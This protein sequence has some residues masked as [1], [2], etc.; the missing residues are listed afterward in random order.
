MPTRK[1]APEALMD[2]D[3]RIKGRLTPRPEEWNQQY[4]DYSSWYE[5]VFEPAISIS[6]IE[7][8]P[9]WNT[10]RFQ[11][12]QR[13]IRETG[14]MPPV[15][16]EYHEDGKY[17]ISDGIHRIHAAKAEGYMAVPAIVAYKREY[18]P[19]GF[20]PANYVQRED[21]E[22]TWVER[23]PRRPDFMR[24]ASVMVLGDTPFDRMHRNV[25][26]LRKRINEFKQ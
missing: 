11:D 16:L 21:E 24:K 17:H 18:P 12:N 22:G 23:V 5:W 19:P 26:R 10:L 25:E 4:R 8:T 14:R 1:I 20:E 2:V 3:P 15:I 13:K 7:L 9:V 6:S